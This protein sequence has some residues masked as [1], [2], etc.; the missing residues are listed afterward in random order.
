MELTKHVARVMFTA[1]VTLGILVGNAFPDDA[2]GNTAKSPTNSR[3]FKRVLL[4]GQSPDGHPRATHEYMPAMRMLADCLNRVAQTQTVIVN[5]DEPWK[6]GPELLDGADAA[7]VFV[8]EGAKWL[9]NDRKRLAAFQ[10]LAKRRGGLVCLH[11]GMGTKKADNIADFVALFGG[12]HGGPDRKY[13]V[14]EVT[15]RITASDHPIMHG[16]GPVTLREEFYYTLK[17]AKPAKSITPLIQ[18]PIDGQPH[19]VAWAFQR[20]DG[21]KSFGFSGCHF[22]E[23]WKHTEYRRMVVQGV[24]W[25]LDQRIPKDGIDVKITEKVLALP[26]KAP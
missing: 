6:E 4:I 15:T 16:V 17:F 24:L 5:A 19:T 11:W 26:P 22:H 7:V 20:P 9:R 25:S 12:C 10:E 3:P 23:N 13:K 14:V 1:L 2:N 18:V 8:S 21:G